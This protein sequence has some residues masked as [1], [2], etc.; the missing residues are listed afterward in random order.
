MTDKSLA[1]IARDVSAERLAEQRELES[2]KQTNDLMLERLLAVSCFHLEFE[3][4]LE[5][6]GQEMRRRAVAYETAL[7]R[8]KGEKPNGK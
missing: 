8:F 7:A 1:S 6:Q 4:W 5:E 2:L 3:K